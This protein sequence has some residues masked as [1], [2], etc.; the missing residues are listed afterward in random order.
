MKRVVIVASGPSAAGFIP[1]DDVKVIAVNGAIDWLPRADCWF[2][3]DPSPSNMAR[4][5]NR[6]PGVHYYAAM[7]KPPQG[8]VRLDRLAYQGE[9]PEDKESPEWWFWRWSCIRR[10]CETPGKIHTGNSAWGAL[11][12]AYHMGAD[13]VALVGVDA[14]QESRVEGGK[15]NNLSHLPL[16]FN[17]AI[18][19]IDFVNCGEMESDVP[20]MTIKDAMQWLR[21]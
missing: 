1:P 7:A 10:I 17:S 5:R 2:T 18:G 13:K 12:L 20:K 19:Q 4:M 9:E 8:V 21:D 6:R 11:Q 14:S 3:L 15:P 16:L